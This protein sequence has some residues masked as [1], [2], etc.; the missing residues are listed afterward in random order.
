MNSNNQ[1]RIISLINN[2]YSRSVFI[3]F[4]QI[5]NNPQQ[6]SNFQI[7]DVSNS[8]NLTR[9]GLQNVWNRLQSLPSNMRSSIFNSVSWS[10][11]QNSFSRISIL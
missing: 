5:I 2:L 10:M 7:E 6:L 8:E 4:N 3:E 9:S 1:S 11:G